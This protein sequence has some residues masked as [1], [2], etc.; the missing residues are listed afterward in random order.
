MARHRRVNVE[1]TRDTMRNAWL[2]GI[3]EVRR[4]GR[5]I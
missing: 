4:D 2:F 3:Y 5:R 1:M